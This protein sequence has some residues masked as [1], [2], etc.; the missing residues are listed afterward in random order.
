VPYASR[1]TG[2]AVTRR[3][4]RS[5]EPASRIRRCHIPPTSSPRPRRPEPSRWPGAEQ[6]R[7]CHG[8]RT[9]PR[10]GRVIG[11]EPNTTVGGLLVDVL[12]PAPRAELLHVLM[13]PDL[14][15]SRPDRRVLG[16]PGESHLRRASDRL[17]GGSDAG[18]CGRRTEPPVPGRI[19]SPR[20]IASHWSG[21]LTTRWPCCNAKSERRLFADGLSPH[22]P[23]PGG[24]LPHHEGGHG[25]DQ[26]QSDRDS[27]DDQ[28]LPLD[29]EVLPLHACLYRRRN[30]LALVMPSPP[31]T[32]AAVWPALGRPGTLNRRSRW[33][34]KGSESAPAP[35]STA[36]GARESPSS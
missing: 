4:R 3:S 6:D 34:G 11:V 36:S 20:R 21:R 24:H 15:A 33:G 35:V 29:D 32:K 10:G 18:C 19:G 12:G 26:D 17:R 16:L 8:A 14:R 7:S 5:A 28:G 23:G 1:G 13:L 22:T 25:E 31:K 2:F 27:C 30:T 9:G